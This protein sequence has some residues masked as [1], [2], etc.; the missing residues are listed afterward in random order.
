LLMCEGGYNIQHSL[1]I[2]TLNEQGI[3]KR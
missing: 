3:A 2:A 1:V